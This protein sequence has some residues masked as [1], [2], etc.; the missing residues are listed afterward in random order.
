MIGYA[1]SSRV[2]PI[3]LSIGQSVKSEWWYVRS[4]VSREVHAR[5]CERLELKCSCLLDVCCEWFICCMGESM[6]Y[7]RWWQAHR[8]R[9]S[10]AGTK[11]PL[12][13]WIVIERC[14]TEEEKAI[15]NSQVWIRETN[16]SEPVT[17]LWDSGYVLSKACILCYKW[18][19]VTGAWWL[20]TGQT[21]LSRCEPDSGFYT[22]LRKSL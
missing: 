15:V 14:W 12:G 16:E 2:I 19:A 22:E 6:L 8:Y 9:L 7:K 20:V 17:K 11:P 18:K 10:R 5:F 21:Q 3:C 1:T 13:A 4:R